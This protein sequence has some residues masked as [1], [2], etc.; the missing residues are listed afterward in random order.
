MGSS[1]GSTSSRPAPTTSTVQSQR[2]RKSTRSSVRT[3]SLSLMRMAA[4]PLRWAVSRSCALSRC[5]IPISRSHKRDGA[6][7]TPEG[8]GLAGPAATRDKPTDPPCPRSAPGVRFLRA[9]LRHIPCPSKKNPIRRR[10]GPFA[11]TV[12]IGC[13]SRGSPRRVQR[14]VKRRVNERREPRTQG[15]TAGTR[16]LGPHGRSFPA[17]R[18]PTHAGRR[19]EAVS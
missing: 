8:P 5:A 18:P 12:G 11:G 16:S 17:D 15:T 2:R 3:G 19:L 14:G 1:R 4:E 10:A 13:P 6:A 9:R 7:E